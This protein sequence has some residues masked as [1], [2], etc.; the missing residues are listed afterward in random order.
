MTKFVTVV[1]VINDNKE[2]ENTQQNIEKQMAEFDKNPKLPLGVSAMSNAD[3]IQRLELIEQALT[4]E[5]N[6]ASALDKIRDI[7]ALTKVPG[8]KEAI[9]DEL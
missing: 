8:P 3:E 1:Y 7:L 9:S 6:A 5:E 2:F 4:T